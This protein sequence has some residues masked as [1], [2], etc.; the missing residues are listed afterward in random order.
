MKT[1]VEGS[2]RRHDL[3]LIGLGGAFL[4]ILA[5][6]ASRI[7]QAGTFLFDAF[8]KKCLEKCSGLMSLGISSVDGL[9]VFAVLASAGL[10]LVALIRSISEARRAYD[11]S[12]SLRRVDIPPRLHRLL[13]EFALSPEQV[14][15]FPGRLGFACTAGLFHPKVFISTGLLE[16]LSDEEVK[17]VLRHEHSHLARRDPL[18]SV[19]MLF[20]SQF[21]FFLPRVSRLLD[22]LRRDSELIA[23][24]H[25]LALASAPVDLA[26]ALVKTQSRNLMAAQGLSRFWGDDL[27][28]DRLSRILNTDLREKN[29]VPPPRRLSP[30]RLAAGALLVLSMSLLVIPAGAGFPRKSPWHCPHTDHASCCAPAAQGS[31]CSL[32]RS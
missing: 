26:S 24:R 2:T 4:S 8:L 14:V 32:C 16:S 25:A 7:F 5:F 6:L 12:R 17:A 30:I 11:F 22:S 28:G 27:L 20:F 21:F 1:G 10:L 9:D 29:V 31:R 3:Y 18:R 19:V 13:Q 23:D 15:V